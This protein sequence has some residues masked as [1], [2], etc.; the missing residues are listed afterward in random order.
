MNGVTTTKLLVKKMIANA[1]Y[2]IH[3]FNRTIPIQQVITKNKYGHHLIKAKDGKYYY[4]VFKR[5]FFQSF[6]DLFGNNEG[7]GESLN[8]E[9]I[10]VAKDNNVEYICFI[11]PDDK[12]Y[13]IK[14]QR[15]LEVGH[16]RQVK[17]FQQEIV[18]GVPKYK[19]EY[20][21]SVPLKELERVSLSESDTTVNT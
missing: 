11:Y 15:M 10:Q 6:G 20:T 7:Y 12:I 13:K 19:Q 4:L 5:E 16:I 8:V 17:G 9:Y 14:P 3:I 21:C 2:A 18:Y 1:D